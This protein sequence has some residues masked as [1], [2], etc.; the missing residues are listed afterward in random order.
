MVQHGTYMG[1]AGPRSMPEDNGTTIGKHVTGPQH[2]R[3]F[4][5]PTC[6]QVRVRGKEVTL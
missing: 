5:S 2:T 6:L 4:K 3:A 1:Q